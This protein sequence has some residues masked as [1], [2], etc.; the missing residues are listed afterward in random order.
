MRPRSRTCQEISD[1]CDAQGHDNVVLLLV[2]EL[3]AALEVSDGEGDRPLAWAAYK[4]QLSTVRWPTAD[5]LNPVGLGR[6]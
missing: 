6:N 3:G 1:K 5:P 2:S 4:G